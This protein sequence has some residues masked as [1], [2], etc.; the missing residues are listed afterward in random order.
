M[1]DEWQNRIEGKLDKLVDQQGAH[2]VTL[3]R[4]TDSMEKHERR[5]DLLEKAQAPMLEHITE[6][7]ARKALT[8]RLMYFMKWASAILASLA[9]AAA[10]ILK[11]MGRI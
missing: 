10:L 2:N 1:N 6:A 7:N 4:L 11:L 3:V 8:S 5:C 9:S